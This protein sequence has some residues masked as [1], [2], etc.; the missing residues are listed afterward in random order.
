MKWDTPFEQL[1]KFRKSLKLSQD[2]VMEYWMRQFRWS[3]NETKCEEL[4]K[5]L[6]SLDISQEEVL[7]AWLDEQQISLSGLKKIVQEEE[8]RR[9]E[10][11]C[12]KALD[13]KRED[14]ISKVDFIRLNAKNI[15]E[16]KAGMFLYAGESVS[17][18]YIPP[19]MVNYWKQELMAVIVYVDVE[20]L[21]VYGDTLDRLDWETANFANAQQQ[22]DEQNWPHMGLARKSFVLPPIELL[23]K[24]GD[25]CKL[26][27]PILKK[28]KLP[29]FAGDYWSSSL[30]QD[31]SQGAY[32]HLDVDKNGSR[33]GVTV[34]Y[35]DVENEKQARGF[36][37]I[38]L[39]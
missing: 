17:S 6:K 30:N 1:E 21:I 15:S 28:A 36:L 38:K 35:D 8:E 32:M 20:N 22:V 16:I 34:G 11:A 4:Q 26:I 19:Q 31:N 13:K 37:T 7:Q 39:E 33:T 14:F 10:Q 3:S 5:H 9:E 2:K 27:N 23:Q 12:K 25:N 29:V 18:T 24:I